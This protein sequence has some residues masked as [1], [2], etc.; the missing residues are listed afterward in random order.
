MVMAQSP[1]EKPPS[2]DRRAVGTR[3]A[4]QR[5]AAARPSAT[6]PARDWTPWRRRQRQELAALTPPA[7]PPGDAAVHPVDRFIA[8]WWARE[9]VAPPPVCED[10]AFARRAWLDAVG[11][12]P[13]ESDLRAF[14]SDADPDKRVRLVERLLGDSLAYAQGWMAYWCDLLRNDEQTNIDDLRGS[15]TGWLF[16]SLVNN[17]PYDQ[18]VAELLDPGPAGPGGYL[19][20]IR[21]R[22]VV[23]ASQTPPMQAAQ[24]VGQVFLG[25]N[26]KCASCHDHFT[27]PY[28]LEETYGLASFFS[29]TNLEVHRCDKPTG[30]VAAPAFLIPGFAK[31]PPDASLAERHKAISEMVT[32][33]RNPRFARTLVNRLWKRLMGRGLVEPVDDFHAR[34]ANAELLDWLAYDFMAHDYDLKHTLRLLMTSRAYALVPV[35][36]SS[37]QARQAAGTPPVFKGPL[38]RRLSSEQMLDGL[39]QL[40]GYWPKVKTMSVEVA[41]PNVRA[42]RHKVPDALARSLGRPSREQVCT[43]RVEDPSML[44][45]LEMTNGKVMAE[46]LVEGAKTL[47]ASP[48]GREPD[49][50]KVVDALCLRAYSRPATPAERELLAPLLGPADAPADDRRP[51]WEDVCWIIVMSPEF[52][53]IH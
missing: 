38:Q 50:A 20:G 17:Q 5:A 37:E 30:V 45:M 10:A 42:W 23:N 13:P 7:E 26:V 19:K 21:W 41:D 51:G 22:G 3:P 14:L 18:M 48:L 29:E 1:A 36:E 32:S 4:K 43:V 15:I 2:N 40:T 53:Y 34:P 47:L 44:Q 24:N 39:A 35:V 16:P 27:R 49:S 8:A 11:L 28:L 9:Q 33:P 46:R 52:Q 6:A 25:T 12:L 31:V